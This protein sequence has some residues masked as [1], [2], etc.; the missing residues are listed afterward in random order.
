MEGNS[1]AASS[2]PSIAATPETAAEETSSLAA[3]PGISATSS[4]EPEAG[5]AADLVGNG[6]TTEK[7]DIPP[8]LGELNSTEANLISQATA[9]P[10]AQITAAETSPPKMR[11]NFDAVVDGCA[12]G[13]AFDETQPER[14]VQVEI[15]SDDVLVA[16]GEANIPR[17]DLREAQLGDGHCAFR[18]SLPPSLADGVEREL[19]AKVS[20]STHALGTVKYVTPGRHVMGLITEVQGLSVRGWVDSDY[21][22]AF[23]VDVWVDD[24]RVGEHAMPAF[25][26]GRLEVAQAVPLTFADGGV[27]WLRYRIRET[28]VVVA[29]TVAILP[30]VG[31]PEN[32]LQ[33]YARDFPGHLANSAAA[34]YASVVGQLSIAPQILAEN[35]D[36]K[37]KMTVADYVRQ[38]ALVHQQVKYGIKEQTKTPDVLTFPSHDMPE[39]SIVV[40][41]HNKFWVTYNCLAALLL[42]PN[43]TTFEVIVVDD[44]SSDITMNLP[45]YAK[46]VTVLRNETP[47]GFVR[48]SNLGG[49][50]ARGKFVI[51]LNNDTEPC[52]HWIDELIHVF[53][54]FSDVGMAGAKFVYP[55][56]KLQEA[57]GIIFPNMD[58]WNYGRDGNPFDPK[59]NYT[60]QVDYVSGACIMLRKTVWDRLGGFDDFFAP[61]YYEDTDLAFRVRALGLKTYYTPFSQVIHFEGVSS[62]TSTTS[63]VKRYQKIN[64]P[65]FRGRWAATLRAGPSSLDPEIAKDRG[66]ALRALVIDHQIPQPDKDAGSYAAVQE[67]RLLRAL[68]FK[69]T[70]APEN[71]AYL[72]NYTEDM[73]RD[74]V[75]CVYGPFNSS[76]EQLI[77][78]RGREFDVFYITRY[79]VAQKYIER[80][81]EAAPQA[82]IIFN[83]ADLHF[84]R[85]IRAAIA[86]KNAHDLPKALETRD[87]ELAVMRKADVTLS[88]TDTEAA[89]I[90]SHNL[91][92]TKV[93][94]CP[95]VVKVEEKVKPFAARSGLAFLGSYQ[96][97]PN[98][99]AVRYFISEVMPML[100]REA[101][102]ILLKIYG[103]SLPAELRKL[104]ADDIVIAGYVPDVAEVYQDC[105]IFIAPLLSGAG[106]KGKVIGALAAGTPT[107]MTSLAG[108]GI[109]VSRGVEAIVADSPAEW[110]SAVASLYNVESRWNEMSRH[111]LNFARASYSV[112][113][114]IKLM[115][116]ALAM[117]GVYVG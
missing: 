39:V 99:E 13:W 74:G 43:R 16:A 104:A 45:E 101:P 10:A 17:I 26:L 40:P 102:G 81:R 2:A 80:I 110:V 29:E 87:A 76:V 50:R 96:H 98:E 44:G 47:Q 1:P 82:K 4:S 22:D 38:L 91:D 75:E 59:Y 31:T 3:T 63:G 83:N 34:R 57:G 61:A 18:I 103:S 36:D 37:N 46:G 94:K 86:A 23:T 70:F 115:S 88:Y 41:A 15:W 84:L 69:L 60:R 24:V 106:I 65:K 93:A 108:E 105:R 90:L 51:M 48:S 33:I 113:N 7:S 77:Q 56:G 52:A 112:E 27:H 6:V 12:D 54:N 19:V 32:A 97:P 14:R 95:W 107:I 92:S 66:V 53:E 89:V 28:G 8:P 116:S 109:G 25:S 78:T 117:A 67:M 11:G 71:M 111:A 9:P 73:Q 42:A 20:G 58:A 79:S 35:R 49:R 64:E 85:Q 114:G 30:M 55:D 21:H 72:G 62:G 68:G 100:R 5:T